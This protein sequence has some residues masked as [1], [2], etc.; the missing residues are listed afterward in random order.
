MGNQLLKRTSICCFPIQIS[1]ISSIVTSSDDE[2]A[3]FNNEFK[4]DML[5]GR[6]ELPWNENYWSI[7]VT[8]VVSTVEVWATLT[9]NAVNSV[10]FQC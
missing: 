9:K 6:L 10:N 8:H 2:D 7:K 1:S 4:D 3:D 5:S